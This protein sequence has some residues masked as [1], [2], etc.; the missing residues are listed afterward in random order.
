MTYECTES[1]VTEEGPKSWNQRL[2]NFGDIHLFHQ[3]VKIIVVERVFNERLTT[4]A[5]EIFREVESLF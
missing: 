2:N 1:K 4:A 5:E 3:N